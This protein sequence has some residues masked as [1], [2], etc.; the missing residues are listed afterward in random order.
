MRGSDAVATQKARPLDERQTRFADGRA[1]LSGE[2]VTEADIRLSVTL[3]RFDAAPHGLFRCNLRRRADH[4]ALRACL[5]RFLALP[6]VR[7]TVSVDRIRRGSWSNRALNPT[8]IVP[9]GPD[10]R[11]PEPRTPAPARRMP[12]GESVRTRPARHVLLDKLQEGSRRG[13]SIPRRPS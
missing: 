9:L 2:R 5:E 11:A 6:G 4:L 3:V 12:P 13:L 1:F 8:G 10:R 7:A